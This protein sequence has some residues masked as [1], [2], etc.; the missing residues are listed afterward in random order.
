MDL[1]SVT[2]FVKRNLRNPLVKHFALAVAGA[3]LVAVVVA[4]L[5]SAIVGRWAER[6]VELRSRLVFNSIRDQVADGLATAA[7]DNLV[8]FLERLTEDERLLALGFCGEGRRLEHATRHMP[9]GIACPGPASSK[10]AR[11][12]PS[13][14][15][16]SAC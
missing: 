12:R 8:P 5:T 7:N 3:G 14:T 2:W 9:K 16:A 11:S 4:P 10:A 1:S 6:D 13:S 15:M